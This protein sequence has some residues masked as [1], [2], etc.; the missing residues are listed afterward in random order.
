MID[1]LLPKKYLD[2]ATVV[3][4]A[5]PGYNQADD[6]WWV[7]TVSSRGITNP[8]YKNGVVSHGYQL[9][10]EIDVYESGCVPLLTKLRDGSFPR[11][12]GELAVEPDP[13]NGTYGN[14][15]EAP[16]WSLQANSEWM[17]TCGV[18]IWNL[19][20]GF[21]SNSSFDPTI[22]FFK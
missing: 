17:L 5:N 6:A 18:D 1:P 3:N 16:A 4:L 8:T 10:N 21:T 14:W 11:A 20:S 7:Q 22:E 19:Y 15:G 13:A 2:I 12:R 9:N